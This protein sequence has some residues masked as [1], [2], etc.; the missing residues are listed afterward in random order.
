M[1][2][3][4]SGAE[5]GTIPSPMRDA[6]P[7]SVTPGGGQAPLGARGGA[8]GDSVASAVPSEDASSG[9]RAL[10]LADAPWLLAALVALALAAYAALAAD[11]VEG[12]RL[13]AY[14]QDLSAWV[15]GSMPTAVEWLARCLSW[16]G[17]WVGVTVLVA[18]VVVWL[19]RRGRLA[20]G[21]LLVVV[22]LGG[23]VLNSITK[24]GYDRPRPTAGSPIELPSSTSFPSGHAMTGIAVFG[25]LGL[26]VAGELASRR[27]RIAAIAAGFGLGVLIGASRVV[28]NV[29]FLTDVLAGAALGLAWLSLCLLMA[30]VVSSRRRRYADAS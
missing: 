3:M 21:T 24:E 9:S 6:S 5:D 28:L 4:T 16:L 18:L 20:L 26:L 30:S 15:A 23:Q 14:D 1:G 19:A 17:G 29:H 27:A 11:V 12:G 13:S 10:P 8:P 2:D 25:L 7:D 22:A